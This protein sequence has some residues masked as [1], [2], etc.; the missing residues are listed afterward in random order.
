MKVSILRFVLLI[1]VLF[2]V[3]CG[4]SAQ[5]F[6]NLHNFDI[7]TD[8]RFPDARLVLS[9][10]TLYGVA[11]PGGEF[12][13]GTLFS[14]KTDGTMF[15]VLHQF[16]DSDFWYTNQVGDNPSGELIVSGNTLYGT[17]IAGGISGAGTVFAINTDGSGLTLLHSFTQLS[18]VYPRYTNDDGAEPSGNLVLSGE[19]LYGITSRGGAFG[20]GAI[21]AVGTNGT[22]FTNLHSFADND[23]RYSHVGMILFGDALYGTTLEG[24]A[25]NNGTVFK[26]NTNGTGFAVLHTFGATPG[27]FPYT[28]LD[29]ASPEGGVVLLNNVLYG[30]TFTGGINGNGTVF[31]VTT[32][33]SGFTNVYNFTPVSSVDTSSTN[34]D[35]RFP[36]AGLTLAGRM[37]FGTATGG[38]DFG[39]EQILPLMLTRRPLRHYIVFRAVI[40]SR[41]I[42]SPMKREVF[43]GVN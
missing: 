24:G 40:I 15:T 14:L 31:A 22:G 9:S 13:R 35:G 34:A 1:T 16:G 30:T 28:N 21:W 23:G 7:T 43:R 18:M 32:D 29:G 3:G 19:I 38:G 12:E 17:T 27:P 20:N 37:F 4:A 26:M 2:K 11:S 42:S 39:A 5:T 41:S 8:G 33:G 6:K 36:Q 25:W 10:N